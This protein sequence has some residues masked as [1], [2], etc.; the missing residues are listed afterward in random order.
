MPSLSN[1]LRRHRDPLRDYH[2]PPGPPHALPLKNIVI[3]FLDSYPDSSVEIAPM[4]VLENKEHAKNLE[5][6]ASI[7]AVPSDYKL[8]LR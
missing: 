3:D 7:N 1:V 5:S 4:S 6:F 8:A 2:T